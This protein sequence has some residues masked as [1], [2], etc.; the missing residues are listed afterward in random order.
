MDFQARATGAYSQA[1]AAEDFGGAPTWNNGLTE[2]RAVV[3]AEGS[4]LFLRVTYPANQY[5]PAAGGVQFKVPLGQTYQELYFSYRVRFGAGFQFVKGGKLPGLV[6]GTA[7]TGCVTDTGGFSA[8]G[9]WRTNGAAVQYLYYPEK[10][11]ACGDDFPYLQS[12]AAV[13]FQPGTWHQVQERVV[14]NTPGAH[15]GLLQ[16]W[17]DGSL[18]VDHQSFLYRLSDATFGVDALYFSTFFGGSDA[19]WAPTS[20]QT[21]DFDDLVVSTGPVAP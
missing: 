6:G 7:P 19:T 11:A 1:M 20:D 13:F 12:G 9:M 8:R 5:G 18:V 3:T 21:V 17:F 10:I 4:D 16:A 15:D 2:G 14:M